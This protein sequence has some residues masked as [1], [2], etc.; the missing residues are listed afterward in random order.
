MDGLTPTAS[1]SRMARGCATSAA[2]RE[3]GSFTSP[4]LMAPVGQASM[5]A[6]TTA[7]SGR[8]SFD[9]PFRVAA[10][11]AAFTRW[12]QKEH[13][14]IT[15]RLLTVTSGLFFICIG[16]RV[17]SSAFFAMRGTSHLKNELSCFLL[18]S[19]KLNRRT[20]NG[21]LLAQY[22]VPTQRL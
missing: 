4:K 11:R 15:P 7:P 5:H 22:R 13:F 20:L 21:Q 3:P 18:Y 14:S 9:F 1:R 8:W 12:M 17:F 16:A 6:G 2:T 10:A 19:Q